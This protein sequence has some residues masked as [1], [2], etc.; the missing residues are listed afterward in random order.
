MKSKLTTVGIIWG[1]VAVALVVFIPIL[2]WI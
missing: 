1:V 2:H